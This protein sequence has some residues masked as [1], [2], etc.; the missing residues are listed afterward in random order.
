MFHL[1][2]SVYEINEK[3]QRWGSPRWFR[4]V[5]EAGWGCPTTG[6][7]GHP[8]PWALHLCHLTWQRG[9]CNVTKDLGTGKLS[10]IFWGPSVIT[11]GFVMGGQSM[12]TGDRTME[13]EVRERGLKPP[14]CWLCDGR[15]GRWPQ[16]TLEAEVPPGGTQP[17][18][19]LDFR[20]S[21]P[22]NCKT[23]NLI[24]FFALGDN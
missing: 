24:G 21:N 15:R 10:W 1:E 5:W 14:S 20:T 12:R 19:H 13:V 3:D 2:Q 22:W 18:Q 23:I 4:L 7:T 17:C 16:N 8:G 9:F 11:R 6:T